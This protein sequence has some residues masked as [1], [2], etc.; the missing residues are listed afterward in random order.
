MYRAMWEKATDEALAKL[1]RVGKD[2]YQYLGI[3]NGVSWP[4]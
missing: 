1:V 4:E 2:G 3:L